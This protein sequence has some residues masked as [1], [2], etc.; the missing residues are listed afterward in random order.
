MVGFALGVSDR[1]ACQ[2]LK[3]SR[4][5]QANNETRNRA[6]EVKAKTTSPKG[7]EVPAGQVMRARRR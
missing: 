5:P 1:L 3:M 4:E 7:L 6:V 2:D